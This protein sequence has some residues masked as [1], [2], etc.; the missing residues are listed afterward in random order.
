MA[1]IDFKSHIKILKAD[2]YR[3]HRVTGFKGFLKCYF[4]KPGFRYTFWMR[5]TNYLSK[6]SF[7][8]IPY[9]LACFLLH[10]LQIKYGIS[11]PYTTHIGPG[12]YIG[13]FGGIVINGNTIIGRNVNLS[14]GVT[15]AQKN[16]GKY[17][18]CPTIGDMVYIGPYSC[19]LG[20]I[21]IG[22]NVAIGAHAVVVHDI[23]DNEVVAGNPAQTVSKKGST[24]YVNYTLNKDGT[25]TEVSEY[26]RSRSQLLENGEDIS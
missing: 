4:W 25:E 22:A 1:A 2:L 12:L 10:R 18:G 11:I 14:H 23:A 21:S 15:I 3:Y 24:D 17:K 16:R 26:E 9:W 6:C 13:H 5:T 7:L 19:I 20:R 8:K